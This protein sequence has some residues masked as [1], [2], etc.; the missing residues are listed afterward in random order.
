MEEG[1]RNQS[2]RLRWEDAARE[3]SVASSQVKKAMAVAA[4]ADVRL[5]YFTSPI[6]ALVPILQHL[7]E[8][9]VFD[10]VKMHI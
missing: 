1:R 5:P 10:D 4:P 2:T 9:E 6:G 7:L 8:L 3:P